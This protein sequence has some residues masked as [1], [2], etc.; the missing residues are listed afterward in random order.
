[1]G[2]PSEAAGRAAW[3]AF[4][5]TGGPALTAVNARKSEGSSA[6]ADE[7]HHCLDARGAG[8]GRGLRSAWPQR[9]TDSR[10]LLNSSL[11]AGL[12]SRCFARLQ[13]IGG[14]SRRDEN[15]RENFM[16]KKF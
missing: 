2:P 7:A 10:G 5:I 3:D 14:R 9:S 11:I 4:S 16:I 15:P 6:T 1:M 13:E 8:D 12:S